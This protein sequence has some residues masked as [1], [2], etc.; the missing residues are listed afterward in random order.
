LGEGT[1]VASYIGGIMGGYIGYVGQFILA[2][3]LV[4]IY[5]EKFEQQEY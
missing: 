2:Y 4:Q 5:K 1:K 3:C